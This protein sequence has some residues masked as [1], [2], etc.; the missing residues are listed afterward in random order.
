VLFFV[1]I[2]ADNYLGDMHDTMRNHGSALLEKIAPFDQANGHDCDETYAKLLL[3]HCS[4]V[5]V[6][7]GHPLIESTDHQ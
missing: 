1:G 5:R 3:G 4:P 6:L 7:K 2:N